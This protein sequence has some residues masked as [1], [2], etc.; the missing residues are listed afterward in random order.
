MNKQKKK[1][2]MK[3]QSESSNR[4]NTNRECQLNYFNG[5]GINLMDRKKNI[6]I[7]THIHKQ[8]EE[9]IDNYD[10]SHPD[11]QKHSVT[12]ETGNLFKP[13]FFVFIPEEEETKIN[14]NALQ[15]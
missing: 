8:N 4:N 7:H 11:K 15:E 2:M 9:E 6:A 12:T 3:K 1:K 13:H 10:N 14:K 5:K